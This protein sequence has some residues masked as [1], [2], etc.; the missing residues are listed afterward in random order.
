MEAHLGRGTDPAGG[1]WFVEKLT[2]EL[3]EAGWAFMQKIETEGGI[4]GALKRGW[5][6]QEVRALREA[7]QRDYAMRD[8]TVT[9]VTDF[10][11]LD[12]ELPAMEPPEFK[13]PERWPPPMPIHDVKCKPLPEIRWSEP[14]ESLR[15]KAERADAPSVFFAT[16]GP[17]AEFN[18]R[19]NFAR[20]LFAVGG[21][22][23][24][25]PEAVYEGVPHFCADFQVAQTPAAAIIGTDAA[26]ERFAAD[27]ARSLKAAGASWVILAGRPGARETEWRQAGVDQFLFPGADALEALGRVHQALGVA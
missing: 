21:V 27:A 26:Y 18:A 9:G 6:Q 16:L 1:A 4:V 19:S 7:R 14:F 3:A 15:E 20:N 23:A 22:A 12:A 25:E 13:R 11:L 8:L 2:R 24:Y 5:L 10:P 17:L